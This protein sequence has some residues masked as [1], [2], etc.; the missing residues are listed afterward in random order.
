MERS[1]HIR[2]AGCFAR[3]LAAG[4]ALVCFAGPLAGLAHMAAVRHVT[5]AEHGELVDASGP[6]DGDGVASVQTSIADSRPAAAHDHDH[7]D[8][9]S[10]LRQ[11]ARAETTRDAAV[12][13]GATARG[14]APPA[15]LAPRSAGSLY[16]FAPKTSPPA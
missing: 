11:S 13:A 15:V 2:A 16:G 3:I 4:V 6:Y 14:P 5:C 1:R 12:V 8:I 10:Q 7:C 9:A